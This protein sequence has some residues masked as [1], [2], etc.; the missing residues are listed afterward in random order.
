[1]KELA[2]GQVRKGVVKNITDFGAFIDLGGVDGLL[3]ITD[4]SY[5]RVSHPTEMVQ[6]GRE[7]EVKILD[8]DWQR[9][10]ISLGMKQLQAYPWKD[11][12]EQVP[13]RHAGAGQG[14]LDHQL[15]RVRRA[16]AG[17]RGPGAHLRDELDPQR[18]PPVEDRLA[19]AR[20]SRRW[21]SR[22]TR[23]RRRSRSA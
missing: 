1:M 10:R 12:A 13:G 6:I 8:I 18:P 23:P 9:E 14:G 15:R 4:M 11:V 20:P 7:V 17:H 2:V 19:S 22:S 21:C 16:R 3:H 5:G